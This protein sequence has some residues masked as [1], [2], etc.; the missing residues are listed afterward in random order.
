[1]ARLAEKKAAQRAG[2]LPADPMG[3]G[4]LVVAFRLRPGGTA[5]F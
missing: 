4:G 3:L 2:D 5:A 1:M